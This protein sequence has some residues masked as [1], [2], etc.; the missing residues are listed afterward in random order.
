MS[1]R[2]QNKPVAAQSKLMASFVKRVSKDELADQV[3]AAADKSRA[4]VQVRADDRAAR[5]AAT[6]KRAEDVAKRQ[7]DNDAAFVAPEPVKKRRITKALISHADR[8][9]CVRARCVPSE[10]RWRVSLWLF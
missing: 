2:V 4:Q 7:R 5:E 9:V 1:D 6:K 8:C 10:L 3:A